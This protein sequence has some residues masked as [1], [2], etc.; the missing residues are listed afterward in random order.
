MIY[1]KRSHVTPPGILTLLGGKGAKETDKAKKHYGKKTKRKRKA[2]VFVC[3][4]SPE[5]KRA[6][7][8]LFQGKCAY[9]ESRYEGMQ[10]VDVEHWRPKAKIVDKEGDIEPGYYWLAADWDNLLPSCIDCNRERTQVLMPSREIRTVGKANRFPLEPGSVRARTP[11]D[12]ALELPLLLNPCYDQ[13]QE[14][15]EFIHEGV[16]RPRQQGS[17]APSPKGEAS[18]EVYALNRTGLVHSR[19]EVLLLIQQR[20]YTIERLLEILDGEDL[21]ER[22]QAIAEDLLGYELAVLSRFRHSD[23]PYS[24]MARQVIDPFMAQLT[25]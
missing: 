25:R 18:V 23:Q 20:M 24:Q 16:V 7:E 12:V 9:C 13:P 4:R 21:S 19:L 22:V 6:L 15:L 1:R 11:D 5:V 8:D 14:H 2:F 10:P 3:Y 17:G